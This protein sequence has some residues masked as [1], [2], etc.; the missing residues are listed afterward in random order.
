MNKGKIVLI[1]LISVLTLVLLSFFIY[2]LSYYSPLDEMY[3]MINSENIE[4]LE[5][6]DYY[7]L[8]SDN[9]KSQIIMYPGGKVDASSY[10]Y[11]GTQLSKLDTEVIILKVPFKLAIFDVDKADA[12]INED[13]DTYIMGHSLGGVSGAMYTE[14]T[15]KV[16]SGLILMGSYSSV[17]IETDVLS[18]TGSLDTVLDYD[19]Y[20]ESKANYKGNIHHVTIEGANHA[21][22]GFYGEQK[23]DSIATISVVEQTKEVID[24]VELFISK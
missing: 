6:K 8:T 1:S 7:K 23:G 17:S 20:E 12:Y 5:T 15:E 16:I 22:F 11:L 10:L 14:K 13:I 21:Q 19:K 4:Y 9:P 18:I 2:T 24:A 3:E